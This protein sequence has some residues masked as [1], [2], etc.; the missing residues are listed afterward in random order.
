ML[1]IGLTENENLYILQHSKS[2]IN[3]LVTRPE[4]DFIVADDITIP[5]RA[6]LA[7]VATDLLHRVIEVK[8]LS[9]NFYLACSLNTDSQII[10]K[11]T[12][13]LAHIHE[14]GTY[15]KILAKWKGEMPHLK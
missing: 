4:I 11:L 14:D 7:G 10:E 1:N 8:S 2:L 5:H 6:K 13:S 3:L 9:L 15:Q 12:T